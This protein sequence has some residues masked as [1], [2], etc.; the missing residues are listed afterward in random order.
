MA[1]KYIAVAGNMGSGKSSLV[2]F[3]C[4]QYKLK[5]FFE[6]NEVNP[7]LSLFYKDM[8][9][10]AFHSQMHFLTHKFRI[11]QELDRYQGTV[12]QDRTIYEDSEIFA[13]NLYQM[14]ILSKDEYRTY[15][16]LYD[17]MSA[18]I[19]PPD[20]MIYL[21]CPAR[22]LKKRIV[23]RN[24]DIEKSVPDDYIKRLSKLYGKWLSNYNR[25]PII[26]F[27]TQNSD[28]LSDFICRNDLLTQIEQHL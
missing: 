6:P 22:T 15:R 10:W 2:D 11:H 17:A 4:K 1:T 20:I 18:V 9:R 24:R 14:G 25:S 12:V 8:K 28:Y 27:S 19:N 16:D 13:A 23:K 3:L 21:D 5:P 26:T 7:Y